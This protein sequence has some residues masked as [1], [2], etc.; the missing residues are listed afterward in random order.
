MTQSVALRGS[1]PGFTPW[2]TMAHAVA[3]RS[4]V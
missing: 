2:I 4:I 3:P 1:S